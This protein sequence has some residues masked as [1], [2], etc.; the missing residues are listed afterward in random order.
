[1]QYLGTMSSLELTSIGTVRCNDEQC[2]IRFTGTDANPRYVDSYSKVQE[3][4]MKLG[5]ADGVVMLTSGLGTQEVAPGAREYL[6]GF[7]YAIVDAPSGDAEGAALQHVACARAWR[8]RSQRAAAMELPE[9]VR[10]ARGFE[11]LEVAEA[12][13]VLGEAEVER[14]VQLRDAGP[15]LEQCIEARMFIS[16]R[17]GR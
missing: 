17:K 11:A 8:A 15:L 13:P 5:W 9:R 2:E 12:V 16:D 10:E 6:L 1:M 7:T 3:R 4:L 14:I